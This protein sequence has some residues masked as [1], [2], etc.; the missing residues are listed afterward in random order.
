MTLQMTGSSL[1]SASAC[2]GAVRGAEFT[3]R[4][5]ACLSAAKVPPREPN[6]RLQGR[7]DDTVR[8]GNPIVLRKGELKSTC[9]LLADFFHSSPQSQQELFKKNSAL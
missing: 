7:D 4:W 3:V 9:Y 1:V 2:C 6:T 5:S 8:G